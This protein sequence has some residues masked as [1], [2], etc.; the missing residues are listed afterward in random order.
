MR[1]RECNV[2][3]PE[4]YT[5]CPLCGAK[6]S[7]DE[8]KIKGIRYSE[9][10]KVKTEKYKPSVFPFF[11]ALWAVAG[12]AGLILQHFQII[13]AVQAAF[14]YSALPLLWTVIGRR[15][16]VKQLHGGNYIIMN[17]WSL[18]FFAFV[19]GKAMDAPADGFATGVPIAVMFT[20]ASLLICAIIDKKHG[21]RCTP[22]AILTGAGSLLGLVVIAIKES[23]FA[24]LWLGALG[25]SA[26][27][28]VILLCRY[29]ERAKEEIKAKFTMQ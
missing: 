1:C 21:H 18:T 29:K 13:D 26:L 28:L 15:L 7:P 19:L 11:L 6:T 9:C 23:M 8:H 3:L 27:V 4:N 14:V 16:F 17:I 2:D 5:A 12:I 22:Y 10:P 25:I 20:L 24:V